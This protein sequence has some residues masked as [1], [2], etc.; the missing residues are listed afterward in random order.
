MLLLMTYMTLPF[1]LSLYPVLLPRALSMSVGLS[2]VAAVVEGGG[3]GGGG[4]SKP[5]PTFTSLIGYVVPRGVL[6]GLTYPV[7]VPLC[8]LYLFT[9][10]S[11]ATSRVRGECEPP[12]TTTSFSFS[13]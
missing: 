6:V 3:G 13:T 5:A 8:S 1:F 10:E 7:S 12:T 2:V 4:I 11:V 9:K